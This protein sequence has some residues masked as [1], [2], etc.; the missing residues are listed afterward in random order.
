MNQG[1]TKKSGKKKPYLEESMAKSI[2]L[3]ATVKP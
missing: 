3:L 1:R 2:A